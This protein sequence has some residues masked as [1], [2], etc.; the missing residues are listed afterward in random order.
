VIWTE[1]KNGRLAAPGLPSLTV[2][3]PADFG[4]EEG[5][6]SPEHFFLASAEIC[7]MTTFLAIA[8]LS[9]LEVGGWRSSARGKVEKVEGQGFMFTHL[10]IDADVTITQASDLD[11][12]ER[13]LQKTE[14]NCLITKSMKTP[15]EFRYKIKVSGG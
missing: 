11:K 5:V 15:V 6:W 8:G 13:V 3:T 10:E 7:A 1:R 9:R 14:K 2:G 12:A 4:G